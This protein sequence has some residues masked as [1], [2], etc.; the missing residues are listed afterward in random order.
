MSKADMFWQYAKETVLAAYDAETNDDL[1]T[2]LAA[3]SCCQTS[4]TLDLRTRIR[5]GVVQIRCHDCG[6]PTFDV[7]RGHASD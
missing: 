4:A 1:E 7:G 3:A 5:P 2:N 6:Q